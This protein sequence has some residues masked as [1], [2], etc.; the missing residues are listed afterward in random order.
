MDVDPVINEYLVCYDYGMGGVWYRILAPSSEAI[1]Q[2]F[3]QL[4]VFENEPDW[5]KANPKENLPLYRLGDAMDAVLA[6][7][8]HEVQT[9]IKR[10]SI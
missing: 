8:A 4:V 1:R 5:W 9:G 6:R 7:I 3:P 10:S 2:M